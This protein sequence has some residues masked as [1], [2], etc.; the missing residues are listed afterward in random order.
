MADDQLAKWCQVQQ[1][2]SA[3]RTNLGRVQDWLLCHKP[4]NKADMEPWLG[5]DPT[6]LLTLSPKL[7]GFDRWLGDIFIPIWHRMI[8]EKLRTRHRH[9]HQGQEQDPEAQATLSRYAPKELI[10]IGDVCTVLLTSAIFIC[11][12]L[13]VNFAKGPT[14]RLTL[15]S[16]MTIIF[17]SILMFV[18]RC[19]RFEVFAGTAAFCAV[20]TV[21][22]QEVFV[23][24]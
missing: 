2:G 5:D 11:S 8:G 22:F 23:C 20:L 14:L 21:F 18:A 9:C 15:V 19:R 24:K 10:V 1:L 17:S 3:T 4:W 7:D 16:V 6:E 12:V 13:A